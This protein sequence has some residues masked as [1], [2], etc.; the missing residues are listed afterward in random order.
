MELLLFGL[1]ALAAAALA[2]LLS[3]GKPKDET[4]KAEPK[5]DE[6][7]DAGEEEPGH[8][9]GSE[10]PREQPRYQAR[11]AAAIEKIAD[12][13]V[14]AAGVGVFKDMKVG[15]M[16]VPSP[17]PSDEIGIRPIREIAEIPQTL[18][19]ALAVDDDRFYAA[20]AAHRLPVIEYQERVDVREDI[21][22]QPR[23]IL[24]LIVD[25]S[26][27]M[28]E[29]GRIEWAIGLCHAAIKRAIAANAEIALLPFTGR[30][31]TWRHAVGK[32]ECL[33]LSNRLTQFLTP[34]GGTSIRLAL[35]E[36]IRFLAEETFTD[37]QILLITD[38]DD[39]V[40]AEGTRNALSS[41]GAVLHTVCIGPGN[42]DLQQASAHYD[43]L[44]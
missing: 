35:D 32:D 40:D 7:P 33:L 25:V 41:I 28:G 21:T 10:P 18:P 29:D 42:P 23:K 26:G 20:L 5:D 12:R 36:G 8:A 11:T 6:I 9:A 34:D 22:G 43:L 13:I 19:D 44:A 27:S 2:Y 17:I 1:A 39:N 16:L 30:P 15:E 37:R 14:F 31:G 4:P 3:R 24:V 38:G